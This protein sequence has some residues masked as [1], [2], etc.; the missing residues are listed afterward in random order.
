MNRAAMRN[1]THFVTN[2]TVK[3]WVWFTDWNH[4][5]SVHSPATT[6]TRMI[7]ATMPASTGS[8]RRG[9][10]SRTAGRPAGR[11]P[12]LGAR[13]AT[14]SPSASDSPPAAGK[15][16]WLAGGA[17]LPAEPGGAAAIPAP[18]S[19]SAGWDGLALAQRVQGG[20]GPVQGAD[21]DHAQAG[22]HRAGRRPGAGH[23]LLDPA[24]RLDLAVGLDLA[25]AGDEA[26]AGQVGPGDLVDDAE[27]E[28][29]AGA[30]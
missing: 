16:R 19:R 29:H 21:L 24:D 9:Q 17:N 25:G 22:G 4:S 3:V 8:T 18:L 23:L 12:P 26:P 2:V 10:R 11:W 15:L 14:Y 5:R 13:N 20:D 30:R 7:S 28:H 6:H 1:R 27:R